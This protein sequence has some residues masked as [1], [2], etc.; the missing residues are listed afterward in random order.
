MNLDK[1]GKF[2]NPE[3][4]WGEVRP[5]LDHPNQAR[6][7]ASVQPIHRMWTSFR[8]SSQLNSFDDHRYSLPAAD[9][10]C[11]QSITAPSAMQLVQ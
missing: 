3:N 5:L 10:G 8:L 6:R 7:A 1:I 9:A 4:G 11:R 2:G